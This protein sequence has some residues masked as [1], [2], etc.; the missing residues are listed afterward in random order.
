MHVYLCLCLLK[1]GSSTC[2]LNW[3]GI[4]SG[5]G[6]TPT[7]GHCLGVNKEHWYW[8]GFVG[9]VTFWIAMHLSVSLSTQTKP[10]I[11]VKHN[12]YIILTIPSFSL[13]CLLGS[14]FPHIFLI[15]ESLSLLIIIT[16]TILLAE[17]LCVIQLWVKDHIDLEILY[18]DQSSQ[19][20]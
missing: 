1:N 12:P 11:L 5:L 9:I 10:I 6:P 3:K 20:F 8:G 14:Q 15:Y 17:F 18:E 19:Y 2:C 7:C 13:L 4:S 16:I